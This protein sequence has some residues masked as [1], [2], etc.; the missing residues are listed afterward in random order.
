MK[1]SSANPGRAR[2]IREKS[3][4]E[5]QDALSW[6]D[7]ECELYHDAGDSDDELRQLR[8]IEVLIRKLA[9]EAGYIVGAS[10]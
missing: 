7:Q 2:E 5:I 9:R 6:I 8:R 4:L 3:Q 1:T 10:S